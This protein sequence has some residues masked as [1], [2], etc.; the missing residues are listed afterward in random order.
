M[1]SL[2]ALIRLLALND[3]SVSTIQKTYSS[4][5]TIN[6]GWSCNFFSRFSPRCLLVLRH[7][8]K[9]MNTPFL[10]DTVRELDKE[11]AKIRV[12]SYLP[13]TLTGLAFLVCECIVT[14]IFFL[15]SN[16][17][18]SSTS[19]WL[20]G[21]LAASIC[22]HVLSTVALGAEMYLVTRWIGNNQHEAGL[23]RMNSSC[24]NWVRAIAIYLGT[25]GI[26][27]FV[28]AL[29]LLNRVMFVDSV[30]H[31]IWLFGVLICLIVAM[32]FVLSLHVIYL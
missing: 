8:K 16:T 19:Y 17:N 14:S 24:A 11:D 9:N 32:I 28:T 27:L 2:L 15:S 13:L 25:T 31:Q 6:L 18:S 29:F 26:F 23:N 30:H 10:G 21:V 20:S 7:K 5:I 12:S 1:Y 4:G 3:A 22:C